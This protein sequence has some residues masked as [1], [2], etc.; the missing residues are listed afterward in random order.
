MVG[1]RIRVVER[2][3]RSCS[4]G[5]ETTGGLAQGPAHHVWQAETLGRVPQSPGDRNRMGEI[6]DAEDQ[7]NKKTRMKSPTESI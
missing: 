4:R 3:L 2:S 6:R 1:D 7:N 5:T